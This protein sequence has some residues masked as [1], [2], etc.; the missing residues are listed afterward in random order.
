MRTYE[1]K[2]ESFTRLNQLYLEGI[3]EEN[4][5]KEGEKSQPPQSFGRL[6]RMNNSN[7]E[8]EYWERKSQNT[9]IYNEL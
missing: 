5:R 6:V 7:R 9:H 3:F 1:H 8:G 2:L 4:R